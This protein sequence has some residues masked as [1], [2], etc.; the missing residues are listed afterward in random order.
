M[1]TIQTKGEMNMTLEKEVNNQVEEMLNKIE[2]YVIR[3]SN[4]GEEDDRWNQAI[5][6]ILKKMKNYLTI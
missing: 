2:Q 4:K 5:W 3:N 6:L 1:Y